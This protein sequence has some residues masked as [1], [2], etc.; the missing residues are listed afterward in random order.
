LTN[1]LYAHILIDASGSMGY[2]RE[3]T[4][5][6][7]DDYVKGISDQ[8]AT[9]SVTIF[10]GTSISHIRKAVP[11]SS[12]QSITEE[13][14]PQGSTPLYDAIGQTLEFVDKEVKVEDDENVAFV[15]V[16]DG[17]ENS[18]TE[19]KL[20]GIKK[21][22]EERQ[23][24]NWMVV[25][26]GANQNGWQQGQRMGVNKNFS[27]TYDVYNIVGTMSTVTSSVSAYNTSM[28]SKGNKGLTKAAFGALERSEFMAGQ[29]VSD[30]SVTSEEAAALMQEKI[31][32]K[33]T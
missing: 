21:M 6:S 29:S 7:I 12:F 33:T 20:E 32:K 13:Y 22:I 9:I 23:S 27:A 19:Y 28:R 18:S 4:I 25:Y 30:G 8:D 3:Q 16:T 10:G 5:K 15:I 26:L 14:R 31:K 2:I 11:I 1:K 24:Q 17:E